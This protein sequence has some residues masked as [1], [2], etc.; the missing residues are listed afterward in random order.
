[1]DHF[2]KGKSFS[3]SSLRETERGGGRGGGVRIT[4]LNMLTG[5]AHNTRSR[6]PRSPNTHPTLTRHSPDTR[7]PSNSPASTATVACL[8]TSTH[9][10]RVV[11]LASHGWARSRVWKVS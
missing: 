5:T 8:F 9:A 2:R 3:R 4:R 7:L 1:M 10:R 11:R 6:R